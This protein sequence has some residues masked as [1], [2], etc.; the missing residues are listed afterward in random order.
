VYSRGQ[1]RLAQA[2]E[3]PGKDRLGAMPPSAGSRRR[4]SGELQGLAPMQ[5]F[6]RLR[7]AFSGQRAHVHGRCVLEKRSHIG[8]RDRV[9][10]KLLFEAPQTQRREHQQPRYTGHQ[11]E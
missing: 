9:M 5:V 7:H 3:V 1:S 6:K 10:G 8:R 2:T 4:G 11:Q